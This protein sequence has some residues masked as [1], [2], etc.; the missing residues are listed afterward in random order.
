MGCGSPL[1]AFSWI[2]LDYSG[3]FQV[4]CGITLGPLGHP[5][6][7]L[8]YPAILLLVLRGRSI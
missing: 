7:P 6:I 5:G 8:S 2:F 4:I 1:P 3:T